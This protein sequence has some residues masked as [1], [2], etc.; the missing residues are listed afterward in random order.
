MR[1]VEIYGI[2]KSQCFKCIKEVKW[3][4]YNYFKAATEPEFLYQHDEKKL[5]GLCTPTI[6]ILLFYIIHLLVNK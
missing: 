5:I 3:H 6:L 1:L 4:A 2:D